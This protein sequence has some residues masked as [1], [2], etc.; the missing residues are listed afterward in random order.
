MVTVGAVESPTA[1]TNGDSRG[2]FYEPPLQMAPFVGAV[3]VTN[4]PYSDIC[5][6]GSLA[7]TRARHYRGGSIKNRPYKK[8]AILPT[9]HF[10]SSV[11]LR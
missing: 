11:H 4:R 10:C 3:G 2:G 5:K 7:G 6:G 8:K 9:N 1:L